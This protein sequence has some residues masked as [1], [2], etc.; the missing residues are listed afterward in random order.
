MTSKKYIYTIGRRKSTTCNIKLFPQGK[1]SYAIKVNGKEIP[2]TDYF[3]GRKALVDNVFSPFVTIAKDYHK[4]FDAVISISG[5]GISSQSD[6]I[7]LAFARAL[8]AYETEHRLTLKPFW[9][10]KR[11]QRI[12]ERKKPWLRKARKAPKRS[13]R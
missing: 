13:K 5:G 3:G 9:F 7:R 1:G 2:L 10:L 12:K 4:K 6:A 11:D 8:T